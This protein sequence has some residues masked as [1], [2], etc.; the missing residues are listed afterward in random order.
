[1]KTRQRISMVW[2]AA[3]GAL[4]LAGLGIDPGRPMIADLDISGPGASQ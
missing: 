2:V 3:L 1:M 4:A